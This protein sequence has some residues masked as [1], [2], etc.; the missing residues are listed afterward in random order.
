M[1]I[2]SKIIEEAKKHLGTPYGK[3]DCSKLVQVVM[4]ELGD[5]NFPRVSAT[6]A[7]YLYDKGL[8]KK[9]SKPASVSDV[10]AKLQKGDVA[11][12]GNPKYPERWMEI[13]HIAFYDG[14]GKTVESTGGGNGVHIG[15]LWETSQWQ[16]VLIADVTSLISIGKEEAMLE[17]GDKGE[18]VYDMQK[19]LDTLGFPLGSYMDMH[20]GKTKNGCDG[21][22]GPVTKEQV[23]NAQKKYSV[24]T[25]HKGCVDIP[26]LAAIDEA[27][28]ALTSVDAKELEKIK[29]EN[30]KLLGAMKDIRDKAALYMK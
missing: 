9:I 30:T 7:K 18:Q 8:A 15:K 23:E 26:T 11:F 17:Y 3:M 16:I 20:D 2:R 13:H 10:I 4:K 12:W 1:D 28:Y 29:A 24:E 5:K 14:N 27:Y 22:F 6:Q 21:S 25:A 19:K